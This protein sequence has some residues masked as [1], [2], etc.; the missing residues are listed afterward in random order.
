MTDTYVAQVLRE[1]AG[2]EALVDSNLLLLLYVGDADRGLVGRFKR[3]AAYIVEDYLGLKVL[4][5]LFRRILTT[6]HVLTEVSNLASQIEEGRRGLLFAEFAKGIE[7]L[8]EEYTPSRELQARS[9]FASFGLTDTAICTLALRKCLIISADFRL[10]RH[11]EACGLSVLNVTQ[12][13]PFLWDLA[14][15]AP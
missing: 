11:L 1:H 5:R 2:G 7:V 13:R 15:G 8:E 3:T 6:P 12:L 14:G 9:E 10:C 4:L